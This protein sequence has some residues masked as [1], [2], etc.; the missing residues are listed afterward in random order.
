MTPAAVGTSADCGRADCTAGV[1]N[2]AANDDVPPPLPLMPIPPSGPPPTGRP[3][4]SRIV[5]G[6]SRSG[7]GMA[8]RFEYASLAFAFA[9]AKPPPMPLPTPALLLAAAC[10]CEPDAADAA[11]ADAGKGD[12]G[13]DPVAAAAAEALAVSVALDGGG[14]AGELEGHTG[15]LLSERRNIEVLTAVGAEADVNVDGDEAETDAKG[16]A[17]VAAALLPPPT[18]FAAA[19]FPVANFTV[20]P[21]LL[22]V[23]DAL[24]APPD[25]GDGSEPLEAEAEAEADRDRAGGIGMAWCTELMLRVIEVRSRTVG[26]RREIGA[27][28]CEERSQIITIQEYE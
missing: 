5:A 28:Q 24:S 13:I 11:A 2:D 10:V 18:P 15:R 6:R 23:A 1:A 9:L 8:A 12:G 4:M 19:R 3:S 27:S 17:A 21:P 20:P 26:W 14:G 7:G 25:M 22:L 16:A